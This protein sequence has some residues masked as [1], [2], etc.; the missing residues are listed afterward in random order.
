MAGKSRKRQIQFRVN[1]KKRY[2]FFRNYTLKKLFKKVHGCGNYRNIIK[3]PSRNKS[4]WI[5]DL[6]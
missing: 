1:Y 5:I 6:S 3:N 4:K 2:T